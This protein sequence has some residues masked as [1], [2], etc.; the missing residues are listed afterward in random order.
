MNRK[1]V[2]I[3]LNVLLIC[4]MVIHVGVR[5]YLHGQHPEY[6]S[7]VYIEVI[8]AIYYLI[9]LLIINIGNF[10]LRNRLFTLSLS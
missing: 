3:M 1:K 6:S 9:P 5:M 8:N 7:P 4:A 2:L 10:I